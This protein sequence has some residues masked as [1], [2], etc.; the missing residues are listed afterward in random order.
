MDSNAKDA[1]G[2]KDGSKD[3]GGDNAKA[4]PAKRTRIAEMLFLDDD[5]DFEEF[6]VEDWTKQ[7]EGRE[8]EKAAAWSENWDDDEL[9]DEFSKKLKAELEKIKASHPA[10]SAKGPVP[11]TH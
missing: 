7:D 3:A 9:D 5:D 1:K 10:N 11:M 4:E 8:D 2:D 6:P